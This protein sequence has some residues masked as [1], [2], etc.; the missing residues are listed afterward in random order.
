MV[1]GNGLE[2]DYLDRI[3]LSRRYPPSP[4]VYRT[5]TLPSASALR[6]TLSN[7]DQVPAEPSATFVLIAL[8]GPTADFHVQR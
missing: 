8:G 3:K 2:E 6:P 7:E 5:H 1:V 4:E